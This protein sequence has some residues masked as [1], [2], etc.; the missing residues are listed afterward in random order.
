M[1]VPTPDQNAVLDQKDTRVRVVRSVPG[2]GKTWL[3]A[4]LIRQGLG[5]WPERTSGIAALSFTRVGGD[6]IRKAIGRDLGH[7]H[8]VGTIDA[9]LFR[10]VLRPYLRRVFNFAEPRIVAGEWGAEHWGKYRSNQ[11]ATVGNG[12]N[13]FGCVH[14]GENQEGVIIAHKSHPTQPLTVLAG[15]ELRKVKDAKIQIWKKCGLLTHSDAALWAS[16]IL[17][18]AKFGVIIRAELVRRFPLLIVDELQ[19]TGHFL[20]KSIRLL[21]EEPKARG[22]LVGDP[23]Q[24]IYEFNGARPDLFDTFATIN[25]AISLPLASSQRCPSAIAIVATHLKDSPGAIGPSQ[26][27][28]GRAFLIRYKDLEDDVSKVMQALKAEPSQKTIR[29]IARHTATV[30]SLSGRSAKRQ[31]SLHCPPLTHMHR[32]V[33]KFRQGRNV[34]ALAAARAA[35]E[36]AVFG[37]EGVTDEVLTASKVEPHDW[38]AL[39]V[40]CLLRVNAIDAT[41]TCFDWQTQ[42][43]KILDDEI[44]NVNLGP[45][46]RFVQGQLKPQ[47]RQGWQSASATFLPH[48]ES[49]GKFTSNVPAQTVHAVKGE[50]HDVTVFV[51]PPAAKPAKCPSTAWWSRND[52]DREERRIAYV[53]MT[54]TRRDLVVCVSES[55]YQRLYETRA[56]FVASFECMTAREFVTFLEKQSRLD[57]P[58]KTQQAAGR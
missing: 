49:T 8:F 15:E 47:Q 19:D 23:D 2:S 35:I 27:H 57:H 12:I 1:R 4:E 24:A 37:H 42:A 53:A 34:A 45:T 39:A 52:K 22:V 7:P 6:E 13:L 5:S 11:N 38:K 55:C 25:G 31:S 43:G 54:R 32:A 29:L 40:R 30:D 58:L 14:I 17:E 50:T 33:V 44:G 10:Y 36:R 51:C 18:H 26:H 56:P 41:G 3:V 48:T 28:G 9:F 46:L 16:R 20:G 21:L